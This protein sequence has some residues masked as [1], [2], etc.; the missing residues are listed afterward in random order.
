M[1]LPQALTQFDGGEIAVGV[2]S[3]PFKCPAA[4]YETAL[5]IDHHFKNRPSRSGVRI[6]FFTP[7]GLPLPSPQL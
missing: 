6:R 1:K 5:L 4:P 3:L 7:E 2:S